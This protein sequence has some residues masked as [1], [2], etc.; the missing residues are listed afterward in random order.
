M[1]REYEERDCLAVEVKIREGSM[2]E[3]F[4]YVDASKDQT[5]VC[6]P[7]SHEVVRATGDPKTAWV[8][9]QDPTKT[10]YISP[11]RE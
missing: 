6:I 5:C 7:S 4:V 1:L 10:Y 2:H 8:S 9:F 3:K 11:Q